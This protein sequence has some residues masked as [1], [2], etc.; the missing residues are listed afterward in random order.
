VGHGFQSAWMNSFNHYSLGSVGEWLTASVRIPSDDPA[1][2]RDQSGSGP[3]S[4]AGYPGAPDASEAV[5]T[6]GPGSHE[7][8][9]PGLTG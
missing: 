2:V 1:A 3:G 9:G 8:T 4:V 5:F 6:V 7:F